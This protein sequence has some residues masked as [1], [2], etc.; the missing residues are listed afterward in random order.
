MHLSLVPRERSLSGC[1]DQI[2]SH[3]NFSITGWLCTERWRRFVWTAFVPSSA[4]T[5]AHSPPYTSTLTQSFTYDPQFVVP[6]VLVNRLAQLTTPLRDSPHTEQLVLKTKIL[7]V[8]SRVIDTIQHRTKN[9]FSLTYS[10]SSITA[11][12]HPSLT[13]SCIFL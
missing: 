6:G 13:H 8:T 3:Q 12:A 5:L 2:R 10:W 11:A 4:G 9:A 1:N 7:P